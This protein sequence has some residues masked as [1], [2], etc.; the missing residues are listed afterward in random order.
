MRIDSEDNSRQERF[1]AFWER[2]AQHYPLPFE[3]KALADTRKVLALVKSKGVQFSRAGL[4]DIG[5]GTGIYTLP[6]ACEAAMVTGIDDSKTMLARMTDVMQSKNI[7]N[8]QL[9]K[10]SWKDIDLSACGFEKAFDIA[11]ISMSPAVQTAKD[12]ERMEKCAR[13]WCVYIGWGRKRKN[14]L[15]QEVFRLH[16][17]HY[18]P[19]PGVAGAYDILVRSGRTPSLDYFETSWDWK[20]P[21]EDALEDIVCFIE[22]QGNRARRDLI[23][24]ILAQH[25][26][27]GLICHTTEVEEG[28]LVW[29]LE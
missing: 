27:D 22:M 14:V 19:P 24:K 23:E 17:L 15:M 18:G 12:F 7:Q 16:D 3:A 8:V 1:S 21:L 2:M 10:A 11:W 4:L 29:A 5:C 9:I 13:K 25:Q 28:I 26:H 20:G 6:L